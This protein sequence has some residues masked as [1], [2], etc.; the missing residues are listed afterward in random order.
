MPAGKLRALILF[1]KDI[2][3]LFGFLILTFIG[4]VL[5]IFAILISS[6]PEGIK[7]LSNKYE[8]EKKKNEENIRQEQNKKLDIDTLEKNLKILKSNKYDAEQKLKYL[9]PD[10]QLPKFFLPLLVALILILICF[11]IK[12][13]FLIYILFSLGVVI[14]LYTVVILWKLLL[15]LT[16]ASLV[17]SEDKTSSD[18]K[19]IELLSTLVEKSSAS[20]FLD[21]RKLSIKFDNQIL[22]ENSKLPYSVNNNHSVKICFMNSDEQMA[23]N[24]EVGFIVPLDFIIEKNDKIS[25]MTTAENQILRFSRSYVQMKEI[26]ILGTLSFSILKNGTHKIQAFMKGENIK[27]K[28]INFLIEAIQ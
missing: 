20:P 1:M 27:N 19:I 10:L 11:I 7:K 2:L 3:T 28:Y 23:K 6:S 14:F 24:V 26:N 16:E 4:F 18:N 12:N 9:K 17:I 8:N 5:P 25:I 21:E 15:V 22:T 13:E